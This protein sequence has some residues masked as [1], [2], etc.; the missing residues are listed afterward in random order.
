MKQLQGRIGRLIGDG[1][2]RDVV[3]LVSGTLAGRLIAI[4][5]MP[6]ITRLYSPADFALLATYLG[7]VS[8]VAVVACFRLD[9]AIPVARDQAD[10]GQLLVLSLLIA[11]AVSLLSLALVTAMPGTLAGMLGQPRIAPWLWLVP[12]GILFSSSY[13]ALQWWAT[14]AKRFGSI[15]ITRVTQAVL[16]AVTTIGLGVAGLAP[17]GL[18]VG[19]LLN[20][21]AGSLR[22]LV[23]MWRRDRPSFARPSLSSLLS[24]LNRYRRFVVY[25]TPE[26]LINTAG[27]QLP[28]LLIAALVGSEAGFLLLAQQVMAIPMS[29]LGSSIA[30]VYVSR[31]PDRLSEGKL[32][33][34]TLETMTRLAAI[35]L[36]PVILL[37]L[38]APFVFVAVFGPEWA[39]SGE[40]MRWMAPW[41]AL[42]FITSPVSMVLLITNRQPAMLALTTIGLVAR[43]GTVGAFFALLGPQYAV[44]GLVVGSLI[45]YAV[46]FVFATRA[47]NFR[48]SHH[49]ALAASLARPKYAAYIVPIAAAYALS[50]FWRPS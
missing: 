26:A 40:I 8:L 1:V 32:A 46:V 9:V 33:E 27:V 22:L 15:A 28:V 37:G 44:I 2:G 12:V 18:L 4:A 34:F 16:G 3:R 6:V 38:V 30:Q 13:S 36:G 19:N 24:T 45:Y 49:V 7:V 31:A 14:R 25:S 20:S 23:D 43:V 39:R 29:L 35:A 50:Y 21:S 5:A 47:A 41:M 48:R 42:Q 10:A 17:V 11:G